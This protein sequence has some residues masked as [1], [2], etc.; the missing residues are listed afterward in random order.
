M[1]NRPNFHFSGPKLD[2]PSEINH[3]HDI[4]KSLELCGKFNDI[5]ED[6]LSSNDKNKN[7]SN[8]FYKNI[9]THWFFKEGRKPV[10]I[11]QKFFLMMESKRLN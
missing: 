3:L 4:G 10:E 2:I 7:S 8:F 6:A 1:Q 5:G 11:Q 9:R